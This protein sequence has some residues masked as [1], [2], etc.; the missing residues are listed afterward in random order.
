MGEA[1]PLSPRPA[2]RLPL[3]DG[4]RTLAALGVVCYHAPGAFGGTEIFGR[5]YLLVDLFF[6]L[7]GFVLTL[8][9]EP[10]MAAGFAPTAFVRARIKRLWPMV[11]LGALLGAGAFLMEASPGQVLHLLL[12][13]LL[14]LPLIS[15]HVAVFPLNG[16][17]WSIFWEIIANVVHAVLL[18]RMN[19]LSLLALAAVSGGAMVVAIF[20]AGWGNLGADGPGWWV[21]VLRIGW[22]YTLGVWMARRWTAKRPTPL[23]DWKWT[24]VLPVALLALLPSLP[25]SYAQGDALFFIVALPCLFWL[26]ACAVPPKWAEVP[27]LRLGSISYPVYAVHVPTIF[28]FRLATG[29]REHELAAV[30]TAVALATLI[31][32]VGPRTRRAWSGLRRPRATGATA[33]AA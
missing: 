5:M 27:L 30:L 17:Q 7:S 6:M 1:L 12:L 32:L 21:P 9:A 16:P 13:S 3:L 26:A 24:L 22:A 15:S 2:E 11:A 33:S 28:A 4:L 20:D 19:E 29:G 10:K 8:S 25:L 31:A 18:R 14:I 23:V